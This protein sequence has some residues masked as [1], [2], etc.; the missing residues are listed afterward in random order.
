MN[1]VTLVTGG[2]GFLGKNLQEIKPGWIYVGSEYDLTIESE[3]R[4]MIASINPNRIVHLAGKVGGIKANDGA[5]AD[6]FEANV[7]INTNVLNVAARFNVPRVLSCLSTCAFPDVLPSY[8]FDESAIHNGPPAET[9][10]SYGYAKR[11]LHVHTLAIRKQYELNYSTFCPSNLYGP[12]DNF[13]PDSSHFVASLIKKV[14]ESNGKEIEMWGTGKPL[15]QQLFAPDLAAIIPRL[16]RNHHGPQPLIV[17]PNENLSIADC[18]KLLA[19]DAKFVFNGK[20]DGQYRKDGNNALLRSIVKNYQFTPFKKGA[21]IT[22][23]W[24]IQNQIG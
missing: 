21:R 7:K 18:C 2:T 16:L 5:A 9:N 17:A 10:M 24:Y 12:H 8:P 22:Y 6:F 15:R 14:A 4:S 20:L 13:D 3:V 11:M 19:P 23:D 1:C